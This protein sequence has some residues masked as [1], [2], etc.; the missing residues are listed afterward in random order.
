MGSQKMTRVW[1]VSHWTLAAPGAPWQGLAKGRVQPLQRWSGAQEGWSKLLQW[2]EGDK[3]LL[4]SQF[5]WFKVRE[6]N[7]VYSGLLYSSSFYI[8]VCLTE[9][10]WVSCPVL[11]SDDCAF[12]GTWILGFPQSSMDFLR[13]QPHL[14]HLNPSF[15]YR[16]KSLTLCRSVKTHNKLDWHI[17]MTSRQHYLFLQV[18]LP[19]C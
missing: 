13:P 7:L 15:T 19:E 17:A 1:I 4:Q 12:L 5:G 8:Y 6:T 10:A 9:V 11:P 16:Y 3:V 2:F 14:Q 18:R